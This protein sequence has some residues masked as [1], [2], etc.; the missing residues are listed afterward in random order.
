MILEAVPDRFLQICP[1]VATKCE[2]FAIL[3]DDA[4][5][6]VKPRLHL[7]DPVDLH[8]GRT[9]DPQELF[10]IEL[11]LQTADRLA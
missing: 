10:R 8:D 6:A 3:H 2:L 5:L 4:V 1:V 7:F 11:L 9:V